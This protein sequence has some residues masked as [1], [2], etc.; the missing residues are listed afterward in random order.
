M[1]VQ[2]KAQRLQ[3]FIR[4]N[5]SLANVPFLIVGSRHVSPREALSQLGDPAVIVA[6]QA[7]GI[8]PPSDEEQW[9]L[10][11]EYYRRLAAKPRAPVVAQLQGYITKMTP[12]QALAEIQSR[13]A[14]GEQL[15][16]AHAD[17]LAK[18]RQSI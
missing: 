13:T 5:P 17:L 1:S 15:V 4:Q 2:E 6:L 8:D 18:I 3:A 7:A 11:E 9:A 14:I 16:R 10:T 12:Q